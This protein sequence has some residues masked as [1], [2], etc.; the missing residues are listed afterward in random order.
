[1]PI[2]RISL[3]TPTAITFA[4]NVSHAVGHD[5]FVKHDDA[6]HPRYGGNKVR[7]LEYL[8]ADA[9]AR[10]AT[11]LVTVGAVGSNHVLATTVHG[12]AAGFRVE[13]LLVPQPGSPYVE[14]NLRAD[15]AQGAVL[16]AASAWQ[17]PWRIVAR[18]I[19]LRMHGRVPYVIPPGGSSPTGARGYIDAVDELRRQLVTLGIREPDVCVCALGSGGTLAGLIAGYRLYR[20]TGAVWGVRVTERWMSTRTRVASL[21]NRAM[22]LAAPHVGPRAVTSADVRVVTDQLGHGY[23]HSTDAAREALDLFARDDI[24]FDL[25]YTGKAAAGLLAMARSNPTRQRYLFWNTLSSAPIGA[26]TC[27]RAAEIPAPLRA[28]MRT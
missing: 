14:R 23:G 2:V 24:T 22:A 21:A 6:T 15:L 8:L 7:K 27:D 11:D 20:L 26:L 19:A 3:V 9:R 1:M 12:I 16:S 10:R 13:A 28:L 5:V 25:T 18:V 4:E 17:V